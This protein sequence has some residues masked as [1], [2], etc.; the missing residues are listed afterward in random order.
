MSMSVFLTCM[1]A[2]SAHT[3]YGHRSERIAMFLE[4]IV[5]DSCMCVLETEPKFSERVLSVIN[6]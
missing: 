3:C 6:N 2:Q 1:Y 4:T 5:T